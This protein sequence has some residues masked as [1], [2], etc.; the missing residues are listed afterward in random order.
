[1]V[2][3]LVSR[4]AFSG[5]DVVQQRLVIGSAVAGGILAYMVHYRRRQVRCIPVGEGWW[6][7]GEK[8]LS[9]EDDQIYPFTVQTSD[10][11]IQVCSLIFSNFNLLVIH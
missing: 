9:A 2:C 1:M 3:Y 11:E 8:P 10:Q 4:E 6:G 5:L 7:A